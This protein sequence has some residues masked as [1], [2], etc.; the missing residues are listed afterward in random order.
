MIVWWFSDAFYFSLWI[1]PVRCNTLYNLFSEKCVTFNSLSG[2]LQFANMNHYTL[3]HNYL[4][5]NL[6]ENC[7]LCNKHISFWYSEWV[8]KTFRLFL[9][10]QSVLLWRLYQQQTRCKNTVK[11]VAFGIWRASER[12]VFVSKKQH[13]FLRV[14]WKKN[15]KGLTSCINTSMTDVSLLLML[16]WSA[17]SSHLVWQGLLGHLWCRGNMW[18]LKGWMDVCSAVLM[19]SHV[20]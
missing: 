11:H 4:H 12:W 6:I 10:P 19:R 17:A 15:E 8:R 9:T 16:E 2:V 5:S 7:R 14:K 13:I 3:H 20:D 18:G 1:L